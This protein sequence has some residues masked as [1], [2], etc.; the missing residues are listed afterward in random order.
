MC[1]VPKII[2]IINHIMKVEM[3]V[4]WNKLLN[5]IYKGKT[6]QSLNM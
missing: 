2:F 1:V 3:N 5:T 4:I 6:L